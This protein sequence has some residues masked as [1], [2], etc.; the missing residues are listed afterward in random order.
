MRKTDYNTETVRDYITHTLKLP[1]DEQ[2]LD[3][4]NDVARQLGL[5]QLEFEVLVRFHGNT[6][7]RLFDPKSYSYIQRVLIALNFLF[8][9]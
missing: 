7:K 1:V 5:S 9:V 8:K 6:V 4:F 3:E 2:G